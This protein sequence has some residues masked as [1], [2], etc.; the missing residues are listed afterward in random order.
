MKI[1]ISINDDLLSKA[2][3]YAEQNFLSRSGLISLA[4]TQLLNQYEMINTVKQLGAL[5]ENVSQ[6]S[7]LD[8]A[9]RSQLDDFK[10]ISALLH[11]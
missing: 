8:E 2:D 1:N 11:F 3:S 7:D 6:A 9:L 10:R 4:L 5:I